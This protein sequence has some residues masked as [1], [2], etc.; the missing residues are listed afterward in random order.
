MRMKRLVVFS[1]AG[2]SAESGLSTFRDQGGLWEKFDIS[3]VATPQAW[4]ENPNK[5]LKFYNERRLQIAK[6]KP[7]KAHL[8][9]A[10]L[11]NHF[12]ITIVTQNIDDLHERA[13]SKKILHLH[14]EI[15]KAKTSELSTD[16][17]PVTKDLKLG[18]LGKDGL[19]LRPHVVWFGESVPE[20]EVAVS[21]VRQADILLVV[22]T[23]LNV[24][25]AAGLIYHASPQA[26]LFIVDPSI[27]LPP[28]L[29]RH[30]LIPEKASIGI[31]KLVKLLIKK[32]NDN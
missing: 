16:Y 28:S 12:D 11:E 8:A 25:P 3:E 6:A 30:T 29:S 26:E 13:G 17:F 4:E 31:P 19:Q 18:D 7:N 10:K 1:G 21:I 22:G 5:V 14:G 27:T 15:F 2:M 23:S 20:F 24:Y 9:L 32:S